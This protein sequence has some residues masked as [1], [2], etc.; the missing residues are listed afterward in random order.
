M[1]IS[2]VNSV[3]QPKYSQNFKGLWGK[4]IY[5][6]R[7]EAESFINETTHE[8]YPFADEKKEAI[9]KIIQNNKAYSEAVPGKGT[10]ATPW[11]HANS[12]NVKV[13]Q[14]LPFTSKEF[15]NYTM[16]RLPKTRQYKIENFLINRGLTLLKKH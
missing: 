3:T 1:L 4:T 15:L 16:N 6:S 12:T 5:N 11:V 9:E 2:S 8:Y 7:T 10:V 14:A 13:M